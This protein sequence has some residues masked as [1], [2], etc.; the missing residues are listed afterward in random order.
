MYLNNQDL[1]NTL[2]KISTE[3]LNGKKI[4]LGFDACNMAMIEIAFQIK[5]YVDIMIASQ[6]TEPG[7]GWNYETFLKPLKTRE[8]TP[9][10]FSKNIVETYQK[11]YE[12]TFADFTLSAI[13]LSEIDLLT[14]QIDLISENLISILKSE[15]KTLFFKKLSKIRTRRKYSTIFANP[16]YIDLNNFLTSLNNLIKKNL[17]NVKYK[18][19]KK[20]FDNLN[21]NLSLTSNLINKLVLK[22]TFCY[23]VPFAD[24]ISIYFPTKK[25]HNSYKKTDFAASNKWIEFLKIYT[26]LI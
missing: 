12:K 2:K 16:D 18:N 20:E 7:S 17:N 10:E 11:N 21:L 5:D 19:N 9:E 1:K 26:K 4:M 8:L 15:N 22:K 3:L 14:K 23:S 25:I 6:E 13:S 24:G